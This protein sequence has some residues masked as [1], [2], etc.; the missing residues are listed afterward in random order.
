MLLSALQTNCSNVTNAK[1]EIV[2]SSAR[3]GDYALAV[4]GSASSDAVYQYRIARTRIEVTRPMR[5][6]AFRAASGMGNAVRITL[7]MRS[8]QTI[9]TNVDSSDGAFSK[10][11]A[12]IPQSFVGDCIDAVSVSLSTSETGS[13]SAIFDDILIEE[14]DIPDTAIEHTGSP[15]DSSAVRFD[16]LGRPVSDGYNGVTITPSGKYLTK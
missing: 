12:Y 9:S 14:C 13:F 11:V 3:T 2:K 5:L 10:L 4:S 16:I 15:S 1:C 8:G 6:T 7:S